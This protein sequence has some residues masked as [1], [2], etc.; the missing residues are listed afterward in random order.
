M[1]RDRLDLLRCAVEQLP[2]LHRREREF[3]RPRHH[4]GGE[5]AHGGEVDGGAGDRV[6]GVR[7]TQGELLAG[8]YARRERVPVVENVPGALCEKRAKT[9]LLRL[10]EENGDHSYEEENVAMRVVDDSVQMVTE[11]R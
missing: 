7:D 3:Q 4:R 1:L 5:K 11:R 9:E 6:G 8:D 10:R 2:P